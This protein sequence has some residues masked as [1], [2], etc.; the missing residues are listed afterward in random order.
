[1]CAGRCK[2]ALRAA[3]R[4]AFLADALLAARKCCYHFTPLTT[5]TSKV[6]AT[7]WQERPDVVINMSEAGSQSD[8]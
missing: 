6:A 1:M 8:S 7:A 5:L 2:Q 4:R 3:C